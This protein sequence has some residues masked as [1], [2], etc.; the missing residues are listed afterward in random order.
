[1]GVTVQSFP[2]DKYSSSLWKILPEHATIRSVHK[3]YPLPENETTVNLYWYYRVSLCL[4]R[5]GAG[6]GKANMT[7]ETADWLLNNTELTPAT[8]LGF[9]E[10]RQHMYTQ[11]RFNKTSLN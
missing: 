7:D 8:K 4:R 11:K 5:I 9:N 10:E 3:V 2:P 1:M 6:V